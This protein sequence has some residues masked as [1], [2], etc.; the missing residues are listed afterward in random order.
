[1]AF[2]L[3]FVAFRIFNASLTKTFFQPDEYWQSLEPAHELVYKYGYLTWEW[4]EGLRSAAHPLLFAG[5]YWIASNIFHVTS[6]DTLV[7]VPYFVQAVIAGLGDYYFCVLAI[8]IYPANRNVLWY[9]AVITAGSAFNFFCLTRTFS[10]SLEMV[11]T[12]VALAYWPWSKSI[13]WKSFTTALI[14]A[15]FS[16]VFRP[17]NSLIWLYLGLTLIKRNPHRV[18]IAG[19]AF[20]IVLLTLVANFAI[21]YI[22]FGRPVF[23]IINFLK[24]NL[25][26]SLAHFYGTSP[27]H[28]YLSQGLPLLLIG[29]IPFALSD[30]IKSGRQSQ[31]SGLIIFIILIYSCLRHKEVRFIYPILPLL[32]LKTVNSFLNPLPV[33]AKIATRKMLICLCVLNLTVAMFF[34]T[35]H[36]RGVIDVMKYIRNEESIESVGFLMPCHSTP[37]QSHLHSPKLTGGNLWF[38]T[39]EPPINMSESE[40]ATYLDIADQFYEDPV[41]FLDKNFPPLFSEVSEEFSYSWPSHLI[42]FEALESTMVKYLQRSEYKE[43]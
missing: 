8:R 24:F 14:V 18:K 39:C 37:W 30:F 28:Y 32:H 4:K 10:N 23:P 7:L 13:N 15:A 16:C 6:S 36:Q 11:L 35:F 12:T 33:I 31:S 9:A 20:L 1:M 34:N 2:L 22:Y 27:W 25:F 29:Y 17:T 42:F 3:G 41:I 19:L 21:D 43:V 5:F 26:E 38:L 40:R